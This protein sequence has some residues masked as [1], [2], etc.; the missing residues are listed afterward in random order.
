MST[1]NID[2]KTLTLEEYVEKGIP[3]GWKRVFDAASDE[4]IPEISELLSRY[5][6]HNEIYPPLP[7]VFNPLKLLKPSEV[8]VVLIG[9]DPYIRPNQAVGLSFSVPPTTKVPPSLR[10]IYKELDQE[11]YTGYA[12]RK[13]GDLL[14]WVKKGVFL[15]NTCLTV[16]KGESGSH[17]ALWGEFTDLVIN[18]LNKKKNIAWILLGAKAKAYESKIS[19]ERH[20]IFM[21]GHPSP[22]NRKGD[23]MGSDVFKHAQEYLESKGVEFSWDL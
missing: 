11:G 15:Y 9:Q 13:T 3:K 14:P 6:Q 18:H 19:S 12:D 23:F 16:N 20:G 2:W 8:K 17:K 10:R 7:L 22:L 4:I 5:S 1:P 21:A